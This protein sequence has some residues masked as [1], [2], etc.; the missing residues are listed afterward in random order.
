MD[1]T[2]EPGLAPKEDDIS[3]GA[4]ATG[5]SGDFR[6]CPRRPYFPSRE[7]LSVPA[8]S[9]TNRRPL[10]MVPATAYDHRTALTTWPRR[11]AKIL[12]RRPRAHEPLN[13]W[14]WWPSPKIYWD[15]VEKAADEQPA[16]YAAFAIRTQTP[17]TVT[18]L[19]VRELLEY[20][21]RHPIAERIHFVD[22][23]GPE[24]RGIAIPADN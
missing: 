18:D 3:F 14:K 16:C 24:I 1:L 20:L 22:P 9:I 15:L 23:L 10:M 12:L 2:A 17:G 13:M 11:I 5:P 6:D 21:P 19:R 4:Y 7:A 8:V